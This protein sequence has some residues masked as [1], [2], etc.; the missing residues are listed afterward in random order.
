MAALRHTNVALRGLMEAGVVAGLAYWGV[1]TADGTGAKIALGLAAPVL[2][3]G[4]WGTIDFREA[5][6]L[7]EPLRLLEE[8]LISGLAAAGLYTAGQHVLGLALALLSIVHH[9]LVYAL[10]MRLLD[11]RNVAT[12]GPDAGSAS[13][14]A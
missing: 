9:V 11:D 1:H 8:L 6:A 7:G 12:A 14:G 13:R 10:G 3:F 5:G 4:I 2:G